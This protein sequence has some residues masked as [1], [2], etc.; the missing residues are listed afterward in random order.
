MYIERFS[1]GCR[2]AKTRVITLALWP[3]T[4]DVNRSMNQSELETKRGTKPL[5]ARASKS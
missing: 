2:K 1:T 5:P 4:T 3:I